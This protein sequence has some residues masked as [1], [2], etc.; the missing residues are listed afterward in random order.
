MVGEIRL[1][2]LEAEVVDGAAPPGT[3]LKDALTV[4]CSTRAL[5]LKRVQRAGKAPMG[6][7]AFLRGAR[8]GA[9]TRLT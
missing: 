5:R 6:A 9:R 2:V 4:A 7:E 8:F 3:L 1:K